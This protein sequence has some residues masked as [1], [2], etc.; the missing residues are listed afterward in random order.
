MNSTLDYARI[1]AGPYQGLREF[2]GKMRPN[3]FLEYADALTAG[4]KIHYLKSRPIS[5]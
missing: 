5:D 1:Q 4:L 2:E 3:I